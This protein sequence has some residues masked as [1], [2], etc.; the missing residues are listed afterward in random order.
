MTDYDMNR[1][2]SGKFCVIVNGIGI[3]YLSILYYQKRNPNFK[4]KSC[5]GREGHMQ[6][7]IG[8][9]VTLLILAGIVAVAVRSMIRD[10][11]AGKSCGCGGDCSRCKGCH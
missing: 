1:K 3:I 9:G 7:I 11:K 5:D 6:E 8:T 2:E 10:K 4:R